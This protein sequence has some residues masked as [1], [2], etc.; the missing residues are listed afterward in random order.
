MNTALIEKAEC[1]ALFHEDNIDH[2]QS[3]INV[4]LGVYHDMYTVIDISCTMSLIPRTFFSKETVEF[5]GMIRYVPGKVVKE[6]EIFDRYTP[7]DFLDLHGK[8]ASC[9]RGHNIRTLDDLIKAVGSGMKLGVKQKYF[10]RIME[11]VR[12][13]LP[14]KK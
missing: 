3:R 10:A 5:C 13:Y 9:L 1:V 8:T 12:P 7:V 14:E 6:A 2:L 4:W 11:I